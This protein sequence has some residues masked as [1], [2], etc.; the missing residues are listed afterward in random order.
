VYKLQVMT[1][2]KAAHVPACPKAPVP[3]SQLGAA[4]G[5]PHVPASPAPTSHLGAASGPPHAPHSS[6]SRLPARGSSGAARHHQ[7]SSTRLLAQG[8]SKAATCPE[9]G[10]YKLQAIKQISPG[11]PTIKISIG[12]CARVSSKA[13]CDKGCSARSQGMQEAAH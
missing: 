4:L 10:L 12:A 2:D 13:L 11:D 6:G 3:A 7:G 5:L 9:D 8:S 1:K